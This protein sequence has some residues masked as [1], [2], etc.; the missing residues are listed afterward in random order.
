M[1]YDRIDHAHVARLLR[2][3]VEAEEE[4]L[5]SPLLTHL[6]SKERRSV[7]AVEAGDIGVGLLE[8]RMLSRCHR[9]IAHDVEAVAATNGP[10]GYDGDHYR[11]AAFPLKPM[12]ERPVPI[13]IGGTG[14]HKTPRLAGKFADEFNVYPGPDFAERIDRMRVAAAEAGR[15]PDAIRLSSSG[16]VVAA[17]TES[18]FNDKM[19]ERAAEAGISRAELDAHYDKRAT[20]RGTYDQVREQLHGFERHGVTRFY[21]QGIYG[22]PD[23]GELLD[24][25]GI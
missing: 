23:T 22:S 11:L 21:F 18:G 3:V 24:G 8:D 19:N 4:D 16:Q 9:E 5:S 10:P 14:A 25:L 20:P 2:R 6:A 1:G 17:E 12:P 15:D 7:A 13:V